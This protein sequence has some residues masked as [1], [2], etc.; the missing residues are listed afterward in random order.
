MLFHRG[1]RRRRRCDVW[2][3]EGPMVFFI[4]IPPRPLAVPAAA[5]MAIFLA[6]LGA[7][8]LAAWAAA[9]A[10]A[11]K[12]A[13]VKRGATFRTNSLAKE[14]KIPFPVKPLFL[15]VVIPHFFNCRLSAVR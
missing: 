1:R 11:F 2:D 3:E 12:P 10:P 6:S 4:T 5:P 15:R 9:F 8:F 13:L 14:E 7:A